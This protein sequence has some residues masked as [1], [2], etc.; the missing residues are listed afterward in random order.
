MTQ[1]TQW[2]QNWI[3]MTRTS[4]ETGTRTWESF[5]QQAERAVELTMNSANIVQGETRKMCDSW[6]DNMHN[7][8]KI[9][10]DVMHSSLNSLDV[11]QTKKPT[12]K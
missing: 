6:L 8:R 1:Q 7:A 12:K 10:A 3:N 4:I 9:C 5:S 2:I 11:Q